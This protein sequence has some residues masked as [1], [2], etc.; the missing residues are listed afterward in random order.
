VVAKLV[1]KKSQAE[2]QEKDKGLV[3]VD[4]LEK[5]SLEIESAQLEGEV[6]QV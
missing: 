4:A 2:S 3:V 6:R 1:A 5:R